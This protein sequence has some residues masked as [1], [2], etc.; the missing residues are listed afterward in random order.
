MGS[1]EIRKLRRPTLEAPEH[2]SHVVQEAARLPRPVLFIKNA[3]PDLF[4]RRGYKAGLG[5][6]VVIDAA[7]GDAGQLGDIANT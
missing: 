4:Y 3:L 1:K 6:K 7:D 2:P 5:G